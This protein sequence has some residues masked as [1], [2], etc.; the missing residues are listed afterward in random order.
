MPRR[1]G[2]PATSGSEDDVNLTPMLDVVFILLIFF[3]VTAQF[4]KEPGVDISRTDVD[5]D[6]NVKPLAILV[7]IDENSDYYMDKRLVEENELEFRIEEL[8]KDNP[9]GELVVQVDNDA[10]AEALIDLLTLLRDIDSTGIVNVSTA[11]D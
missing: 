11:Q 8:R 3:I 10:D 7:A 6:D 4:I 9:K 1:K 5:N 2:I